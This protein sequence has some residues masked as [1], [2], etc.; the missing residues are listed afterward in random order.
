[1]ARFQRLRKAGLPAPMLS[2][3]S[4]TAAGAPPGKDRDARVCCSALL[5]GLIVC[6]LMTPRLAWRLD[7]SDSPYKKR[8][9]WDTG[10]LNRPVSCERLSS[11]SP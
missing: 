9:H 10:Q 8:A 4:G 6:I 3:L 5:A 1:M 7:K 11:A 2:L